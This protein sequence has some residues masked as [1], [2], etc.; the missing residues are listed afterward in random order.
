MY[1]EDF[2]A[3]ILAVVGNSFFYV[4][5]G[6]GGGGAVGYHAATAS[7]GAANNS[8]VGGDGGSGV[9]IIRY[10]VLVADEVPLSINSLGNL[11]EVTFT[12]SAKTDVYGGQVFIRPGTTATL[13][14]T[15]AGGQVATAWRDDATGEIFWGESVEVTPAVQTMY[16]ALFNGPWEWNSATKEFYEKTDRADRWVL[17][18]KLDGSGIKL[19]SVKQARSDGFLNVAFLADSAAAQIFD[20][21]SGAFAPQYYVKELDSSCFKGESRVKTLILPENFER[22]SSSCLAEADGPESIC[23]PVNSFLSKDVFAKNTA[24]RQVLFKDPANSK[25]SFD[26][27]GGQFAETANLATIELPPCVKTVPEG[28]F[29]SS[30]LQEASFPGVVTFE[31]VSMSNCVSLVYLNLSENLE[32][33]GDGAFRNDRLLTPETIRPYLPSSLK[34]IGNKSFMDC[35]G[36]VA[37]PAMEGVVNLTRCCFERCPLAGAVSLPSATT[38]GDYVFKDTKLTSVTMA[39][40]ERIGREA[41]NGAPLEEVVFGPAQVTFTDPN[42]VFY[43]CAAGCRFVFP[44]KAPLLPPAACTDGTSHG[45]GDY[46]LFGGTDSAG[47]Y[48]RI[49]GYW[50]SD[51]DGWAKILGEVGYELDA[52]QAAGLPTPPVEPGQK[53]RGVFQWIY[54]KGTTVG[55]ATYYKGWLIDLSIYS[56]MQLLIW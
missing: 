20:A 45:C 7:A 19:G 2:L 42:R 40:I 53:A 33:I 21:A 4:G 49:Y 3:K 15:D 30:G 41:F 26:T 37:A 5:Y 6:G 47:K 51:P 27:R 31:N 18:A 11:G 10:T 36:L 39:K 1:L 9:V 25:V 17:N 54:D 24:L 12:G 48:P 56:G 14:A 38:I 22:F 43:S 8:I 52:P 32:T 23:V 13:S 16:T 34:S 50:R 46:R 28:C 55:A 35:A 44:G 29:R